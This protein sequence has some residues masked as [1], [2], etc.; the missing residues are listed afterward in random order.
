MDHQ[1]RA[2]DEVQRALE[3]R[4]RDTLGVHAPITHRWAATVGYTDSGL[5]VVGEVRPGVWAIG[6]YCGT[7]NVRRLAARAWP[8]AMARGRRRLAG[9]VPS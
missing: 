5:P 8:R 4:L 1:C 2:H 9:A 6:G 7:G 3:R